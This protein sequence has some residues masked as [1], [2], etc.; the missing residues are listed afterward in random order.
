MGF[1][2]RLRDAFTR[3][4]TPRATQAITIE[5]PV[6]EPPKRLEPKTY[7][8]VPLH[9]ADRSLTFMI[10]KLEPAINNGF[11]LVAERVISEMRASEDRIIQHIDNMQLTAE[12][13]VGKRIT[14]DAV[15]AE[16]KKRSELRTEELKSMLK[17]TLGVKDVS[18][19]ALINHLARLNKDGLIEHAEFGKYRLREGPKENTMVAAE[20]ECSQKSYSDV[21]VENKA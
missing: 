3:K 15:L 4:E 16:F 6:S 9:M 19:S 20:L 1:F 14:R 10:D 11:K 7:D 18:S 5:R 13:E 2:D 17:E 21:S 12:S 8:E